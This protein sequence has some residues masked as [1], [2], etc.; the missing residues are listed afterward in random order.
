MLRSILLI[1]VAATPAST[2][3]VAPPTRVGTLIVAPTRAGCALAARH[4]S[5][6][7][8]SAEPPAAGDA[9]DDGAAAAADPATP[10]TISPPTPGSTDANRLLGDIFT[11]VQSVVVTGAFYFFLLQVLDDEW[12]AAPMGS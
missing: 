6:I 7:S 5:R 10:E 4:S 1:L 9:A 12:L 11:I 8:C 2:L 3:L